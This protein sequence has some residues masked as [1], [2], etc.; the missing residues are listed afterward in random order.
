MIRLVAGIG[1]ALVSKD[2]DAEIK[3]FALGSCVAFIVLDPKVRGAGLVH[4]AL[5][6]AKINPQKAQSLPCYFAD[7]GI[8]HL[9]SL[10]EGIG[11]FFHPGLIIKMVGG[12]QIGRDDSLFDVGGRNITAVKKIMWSMQL[13]IR[14]S[15]V[16]GN[17]SRTVTIIVHSGKCTISGADGK[18]WS[19]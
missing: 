3:T 11:S 18:I 15:D 5:P 7:T 16:G 17:F 6:E 8:A 19:V 1:E 2:P 4:I 13:P 14:A 9:F 10:M 12:A